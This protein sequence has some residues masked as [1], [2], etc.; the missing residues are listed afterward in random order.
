MFTFSP[1]IILRHHRE[2]LKKCSLRGL[3]T[4]CDYQF[5]TYPND[6][7]PDLSHYFLLTLDAPPLSETDREMGIFLIDGTWRY[8]EVM[9]RQLPKPHL[10][11][12]RSLPP[13]FQTAYP[14]KQTLCPEPSRGLASVEALFVAHSFLGRSTAGLLD[15]FHWKDD[16]LKKNAALL[17]EQEVED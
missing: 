3:E 14:R 4:R 5:F 12:R 13:G 10:F 7:L 11:Q 6:A 1:T 8:A 15:N 9:E 17:G 16:F 2:N